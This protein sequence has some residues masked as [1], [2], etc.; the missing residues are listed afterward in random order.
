MLGL[1]LI[2][3]SIYLKVVEMHTQSPDCKRVIFVIIIIVNASLLTHQHHPR[4]RLRLMLIHSQ[5]PTVALLTRSSHAAAC[6]LSSVGAA[7]F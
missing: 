7:G 6:P 4:Q 2:Y 5:K 1:G 3:L